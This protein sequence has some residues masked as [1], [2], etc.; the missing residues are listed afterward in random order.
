LAQGSSWFGAVE[1]KL[2]LRM[3]EFLADIRRELPVEKA[4]E[5][6]ATLAKIMGNVL[7]NPGEPKFRTLK[8]DKKL[9]TDNICC[10]LAA[11]SLLL[12][13]GFEDQDDTYHCPMTTDL[14]HMEEAAALLHHMVMS[15]NAL[16]KP[17]RPFTHL[18][19]RTF[20]IKGRGSSTVESLRPRVEPAQ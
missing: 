2:L 14:E 20:E 3:E 12:A 16:A 10:S 7:R 18:L 15:L 8:K 13:V 19:P 11:V 17:V 6:Y 4:S 9:V 1:G 5:V